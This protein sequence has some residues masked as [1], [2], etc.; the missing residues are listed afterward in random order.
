[1][2]NSL[3]SI[4][5]PYFNSSKTVDDSIK[6]VIRQEYQDWELLIVNDCS[7]IEHTDYLRKI[8]TVFDEPRIKLF[9]LEVNLGA[10]EARNVALK[11]AK[12]RFI[13]FLDSDDTWYPEKLEKQVHF[14]LE[15]DIAFSFSAYDVMNEDGSALNKTI[16]V[17]AT[18][19]KGQY[20]RNTIIGCLT[21]LLDRT[22]FSN[23]ILMP[24]LRS[25]HDMALWVNLLD[26]VDIA[27]GY[28]GALASYRLV[29]S[30][31]TANKT[32]AAKE[33]WAVYRK[34]F[35]YSLIRSSFYFMGYAYNAILK[36][37]K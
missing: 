12:G 31:N 26:D 17:P 25:S 29:N 37:L 2:K 34:Y 7:N 32:K 18:I 16:N 27:Y 4:I 30:S 28:E 20:L 19:S 9:D 24:N 11:R 36:R 22:K 6:S 35:K 21:V 8:L 14:M 1:M 13:A 3:V 15:K 10:A 33:V 23:D 5:M